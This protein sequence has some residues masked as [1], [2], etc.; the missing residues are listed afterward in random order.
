[1]W[2]G[3]KEEEGIL[4]MLATDT[5]LTIEKKFVQ[6]FSV[7]NCTHTIITSNSDWYAPLGR[8]D[9]RYLTLKVDNSIIG[10]YE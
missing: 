1:M 6:K 7:P 4:K 10:N 8:T 3:R 5:T 2:G 9:R